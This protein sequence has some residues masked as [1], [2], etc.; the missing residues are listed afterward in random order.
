MRIE[1]LEGE[2]GC[3]GVEDEWD[4]VDQRSMID[5]ELCRLK[6]VEQII[7]YKH[8]YA[9]L[10]LPFTG[11]CLVFHSTYIYSLIWLATECAPNT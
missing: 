6:P 7:L 9:Y 3:D 1:T 5:G 4:A 10:E 8:I 11:I 2:G